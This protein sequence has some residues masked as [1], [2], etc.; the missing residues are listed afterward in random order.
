M[1]IEINGK[2]IDTLENLELNPLNNIVVSELENTELNVNFK[3]AEIQDS[4][5]F[6]FEN[7]ENLRNDKN[8]ILSDSQIF[9]LQDI[10]S[11]LESIPKDYEMI[12]TWIESL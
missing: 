4:L 7:L 2:I 12:F 5:N 3:I 11:N 1:K 8:L 10:K 9:D 6:V